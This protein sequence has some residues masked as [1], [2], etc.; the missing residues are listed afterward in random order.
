MGEAKT[1]LPLDEA[2]GHRN[3][4]GNDGSQDELDGSSEASAEESGAEDL[5]GMHLGYTLL[6]TGPDHFDNDSGEESDYDSPPAARL[7]EESTL[8]DGVAIDARLRR[9]H[10]CSDQFSSIS[11]KVCL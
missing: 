6:S 9:A 2:N 11:S 8:S 10:D 4:A 3:S 5:S 1:G 7:Q